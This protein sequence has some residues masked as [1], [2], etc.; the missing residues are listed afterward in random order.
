MDT[1]V[2]VALVFFC[3]GLWVGVR[4]KNSRSSDIAE[5]VKL[6]EICS[7]MFEKP[8]KKKGKK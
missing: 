1:I 5:L 8:K 4:T 2:I 3:I 7:S 6:L